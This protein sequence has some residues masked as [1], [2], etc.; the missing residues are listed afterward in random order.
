MS[1]SELHNGLEML[2]SLSKVKIDV[3]IIIM[4]GKKGVATAVFIMRWYCIALF[5]VFC[6]WCLS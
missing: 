5:A 2:L 1:V 6:T 4:T 3:N